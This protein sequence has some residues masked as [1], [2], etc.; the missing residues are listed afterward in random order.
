MDSNASNNIYFKPSYRTTEQGE[1]SSKA[2]WVQSRACM[3]SHSQ[4]Q[5]Q[6]LA[7][8]PWLV[9]KQCHGTAAW[10]TPGGQREWELNGSAW[11]QAAGQQ[12][13]PWLSSP[14]CTTGC[15]CCLES[16]RAP[17][18]WLLFLDLLQNTTK[19]MAKAVSTLSWGSGTAQGSLTQLSSV[20]RSILVLL[21]RYHKDD[22]CWTSHVCKVLDVH[23]LSPRISFSHAYI[24][25]KKIKIRPW[26]FW[27]CHPWQMK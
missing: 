24:K 21:F 11:A 8:G 26:K 2:S 6:N 9:G 19:G 5:T 7:A 13:V 20:Q 4:I 10:Q 1:Q 16:Y 27:P 18:P 12:E 15:P 3:N 23:S 17:F 22:T 25:E 14:G